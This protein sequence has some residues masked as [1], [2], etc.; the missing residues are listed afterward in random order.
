MR[1]TRDKSMLLIEDERENQ[2][3]ERDELEVRMAEQRLK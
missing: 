2:K 1:K 3:K